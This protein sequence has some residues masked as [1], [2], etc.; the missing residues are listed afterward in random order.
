MQVGGGS[1][2]VP[3][4]DGSRKLCTTDSDCSAGETCVLGSGF[5]ATITAVDGG[6]AVT[7]VLVTNPGAGYTSLPKLVASSAACTCG[8]AAGNVAGNLDTCLYVAV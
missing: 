7:S 6:G 2:S 1:C 5:A 4:D 8:G 3:S